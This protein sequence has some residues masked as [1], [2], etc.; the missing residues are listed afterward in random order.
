MTCEDGLI[1]SSSFS[2]KPKKVKMLFIMSDFEWR[3]KIGKKEFIIEYDGGN[4]KFV[5]IINNYL[6][7][8]I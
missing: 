4:K 8:K 5:A 3:K 1:L 7:K 2:E 6:G